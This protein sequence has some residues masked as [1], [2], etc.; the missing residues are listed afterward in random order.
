MGLGDWLC[1]SRGHPE[2][3]GTHGGELV[4][5]SRAGIPQVEARVGAFTGGRLTVGSGIRE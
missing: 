5:L 4:G 2:L 3:A 1:C